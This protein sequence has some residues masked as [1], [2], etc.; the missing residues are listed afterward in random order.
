M[1]FVVNVKLYS[2]LVNTN[3][4]SNLRRNSESDGRFIVLELLFRPKRMLFPLVRLISYEL[5]WLILG[6]NR[7]AT[8]CP[9]QQESGCRM[10]PR[11]ANPYFV[12]TKT[13]RTFQQ[14]LHNIDM[15]SF[16]IPN[17]SWEAAIGQ[18]DVFHRRCLSSAIAGIFGSECLRGPRPGTCKRCVVQRH[19][20]CCPHLPV[21]FK[22]AVRLS[23]QNSYI[24]APVLRGDYPGDSVVCG[25]AACQ[26]MSG[27]A[28]AGLSPPRVVLS[29]PGRG[30]IPR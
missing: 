19:N 21:A 16:P 10:A 6:I 11:R 28:N 14:T 12:L 17:A 23:N 1:E 7:R 13:R 9:A 25:K 26:L 27:I 20:P 15:S 4:F 8:F 5:V 30:R 24:S 22:A 29:A 2:L 3:H 18:H